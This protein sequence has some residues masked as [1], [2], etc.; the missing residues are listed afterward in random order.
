MYEYVN[1]RDKATR[2]RWNTDRLIVA[3]GVDLRTK[4]YG[5]ECEEED[6][7]KTEEDQQ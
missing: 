4:H 1:Q 3:D 7:F 6:G 5:C 2:T